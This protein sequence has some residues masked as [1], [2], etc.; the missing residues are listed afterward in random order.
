MISGTIEDKFLDDPLFEPVLA[1]AEQLDVPIYIHPGIPPERVRN[2][3][4]D[5]FCPVVSIS[6][7]TAGWG[8]HAETAVHVLRM[9]LS[10]TLD[11]HPRLK[12]IIGH[13]GEGLPTM[14][15]RCDDWLTPER[16]GLQRT[17]SETIL[18][19][20][21]ITTAGFFTLPPFLAALL[22]FGADRILFSVDYPFS[23]N[24][25]ARRFLDALPLPPNDNEKIAHGNAD[26]LLRLS[27]VRTP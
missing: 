23:D 2:I 26:R 21:T 1:R 5:G 25:A 18:D 13:M 3:Y 22:T 27:S 12:L 9:V 16:T 19:H 15:A 20:V 7:A 4:Y 24:A 8:W 14:L 6:F 11:R 17:V 10:G